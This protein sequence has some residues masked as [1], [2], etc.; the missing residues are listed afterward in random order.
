MLLKETRLELCSEVVH[1]DGV[2]RGTAQ[3]SLTASSPQ[4]SNGPARNT[5]LHPRSGRASCP[6]ALSGDLVRATP[7]GLDHQLE[8]IKRGT[9]RAESEH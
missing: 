9:S 5:I 8:S 4:S 3:H 1:V 7:M 6:Q 2:L